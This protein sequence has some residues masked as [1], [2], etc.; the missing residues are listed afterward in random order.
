[1]FS[2]RRVRLTCALGSALGAGPAIA[3]PAMAQPFD[4]G[5]DRDRDRSASLSAMLTPRGVVGEDRDQNGWG[6]VN[7]RIRP[8]TGQICFTYA[9]RNV[10]D[11]ENIYVY[12]GGPRDYNRDRDVEIELRDSGSYGSGCRHISPRVA[13]AMVREPGRYNVQ[14]DGD[15]GAIRGQLRGRDW[16]D[17]DWDDGDDDGGHHR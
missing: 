11:P 5:H 4:N 9:V 3:A 8:M 7:L 10:D 17:D 12:F 1:M 16:D 14:V 13:F 6:T 2:V 15:D